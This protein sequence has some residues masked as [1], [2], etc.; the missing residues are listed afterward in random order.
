M[1]SV[2]R[3]K[4][5][6][7]FL[8]KPGRCFR[9]LIF[10]WTT[11]NIDPWD[12][13]QKPTNNNNTF[14]T[15]GGPELFFRGKNFSF[16]KIG[17]CW[18]GTIKV[19]HFQLSIRFLQT[20]NSCSDKQSMSAPSPKRSGEGPPLSTS[21]LHSLHTLWKVIE[22]L[23]L[24]TAVLGAAACSQQRRHTPIHYNIYAFIKTWKVV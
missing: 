11:Q 15:I 1:S 18:V 21:A 17:D 22:M 9:T 5:H 13:R 20:L 24:N 14:L 23:S 10:W 8:H 6:T 7:H 19:S 3:N 4:A 12:T 2:L 16:H